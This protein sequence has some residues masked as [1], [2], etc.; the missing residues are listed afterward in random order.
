M[1]HRKLLTAKEQEAVV[2][3]LPEIK[4]IIA[5]FDTAA[6]FSKMRGTHHS[7]KVE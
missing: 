3:T 2:V 5:Q 6:D 7:T 1:K 4:T